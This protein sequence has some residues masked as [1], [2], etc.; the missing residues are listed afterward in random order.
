MSRSLMTRQQV[1]D[2]LNMGPDWFYRNRRGLEAEGWNARLDAWTAGK[3]PHPF[4]DVKPA[5]GGKPHA[6]GPRKAMKPGTVDALIQRY[7]N[8]RAFLKL[9]ES[10]QKMYSENLE[11]ISR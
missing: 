10:T 2:R 4:A 7:K 8:A 9:R 1:A 6:Q 11:I 3:G 5:E